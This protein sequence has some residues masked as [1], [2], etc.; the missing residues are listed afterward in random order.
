[1][2]SKMQI[3][4]LIRGINIGIIDNLP[5]DGKGESDIILNGKASFLLRH[6]IRNGTIAP[7][8][9]CGRYEND[10]GLICHLKRP[11]TFTM[12]IFEF[13]NTEYRLEFYDIVLGGR[14]REECNHSLAEVC[15]PR[16]PANWLATRVH[17]SQKFNVPNTG[18]DKHRFSKAT[19]AA[20][21]KHSLVDICGLVSDYA[22]VP[23]VL[24]H[25]DAAPASYASMGITVSKSRQMA[26]RDYDK[27]NNLLTVTGNN[28]VSP[29]ELEALVYTLVYEHDN[30]IP[31]DASIENAGD[32]CCKA[33]YPFR[34]EHGEVIMILVR[35]YD[36][37]HQAKRL[38]PLTAWSEPHRV[39]PLQALVPLSDKQILYNLDLLSAN[40]A[41][42]VILVDAV[43]IA[44][45]NQSRCH[46]SEVIWTS[47]ICDEGQFDQV[48]WE[49]LKRRSV[50][51]LVTN[52]SG[53]SLAEQYA[54]AKQL[55]SFLRETQGIELSFAQME[56]RYPH[57]QQPF[58]DI[59]DFR[60]WWL[61]ERRETVE[62][63]IRVMDRYEF[64]LMA[65]KAAA[66]LLARPFWADAEVRLPAVK[67]AI[68]EK[69]LSNDKPEATSYLI[70]PA[71]SQNGL[72]FL[73]AK[74]GV[75][76]SAVATSLCASIISGK[77]VFEDVH[78]TMPMS[79]RGKSRILY[80]DLEMDPDLLADRMRDF[81]LPYLSSD[82]NEQEAQLQNFKIESLLDKPVDFTKQEWQDYVLSKMKEFE[83][84]GDHDIPVK[85]VVFDTYTRMTGGREGPGSWKLI[86]PMIQAIQ[87]AGA[88]VLILHHLNRKGDVRGFQEKEFMATEVL[89]MGR[90]GDKQGSLS[91]PITMIPFN[92]RQSKIAADRVQFDFGLVKKGKETACRWTVVKPLNDPLALFGHIAVDY[93]DKGYP[94]DA[95]CEM[96]GMGKSAYHEKLKKAEALLKKHPLVLSKE[97]AKKGG[98]GRAPAEIT[99]NLVNASDTPLAI[100]DGDEFDN[101]A[102]ESED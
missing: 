69:A 89:L 28:E 97:K 40:P 53:V 76:K 8:L 92:L 91:E 5:R 21:S 46:N 44:E 66:A 6:A 29:A 31:V 99:V 87:K 86:T 101:D 45:A 82:K 65:E 39:K 75:G 54:R 10:E 61:T 56:T 96:L 55:A 71:V 27:G 17:D 1:M 26:F 36:W 77:P 84:Q 57:R 25:F 85:L 83:S 52:H 38:I 12:P 35:T 88:S 100:S 67:D 47:W 95:I 14:S 50:C 102:V 48:E 19:L 72:T 73:C 68:M 63:S 33:I 37:L 80:F 81:F 9:G 30:E 24:R 41:A 42:Q 22:T 94:R 58:S 3:E 2:L 74:K 70:R 60:H 51:Y 18:F 15:S 79:I 62:G 93:Q 64:D 32:D 16:L 23:R 90:D 49:P 59:T 4:E 20:L 43:E 13:K 98:G 78:W 34:D 11:V 7:L